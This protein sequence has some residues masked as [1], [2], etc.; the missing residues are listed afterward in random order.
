MLTAR[1]GQSGQAVVRIPTPADRLLTGRSAPAVHPQTCGRF[2][3][4]VFLVGFLLMALGVQAFPQAP[5][6]AAFV[7]NVVKVVL[8]HP[9]NKTS[10]FHPCNRTSAYHR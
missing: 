9:C 5:K 3:L 2:G 8:F 10:A 7:V 6:S 4:G 1:Q